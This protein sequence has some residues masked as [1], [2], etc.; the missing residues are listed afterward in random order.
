MGGLFRTLASQ[1]SDAQIDEAFQ[2]ITGEPMARLIR[3]H[4]SFNWHKSMILALWRSSAMRGFLWRA[5]MT[6]SGRIIGKL[7]PSMEAYHAMQ[8]PEEHPV[9]D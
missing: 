9:R 5:L 2:L 8:F 3:D 6:R 7:R 1:L 4:A